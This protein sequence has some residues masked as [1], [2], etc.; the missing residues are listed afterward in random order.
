MET[1]MIQKQATTIRIKLCFDQCF[2]VDCH[3]KS[4]GLMLLWKDSSPVEIQN[5]SRRHINAVV[6]CKLDAPLWMLTGFYRHPEAAKRGEPWA[7][8]RHLSKLNSAPW[9]CLGDFNEIT[10]AF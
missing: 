9:L 8:L 7:L 10:S 6:R 3:G 2:V 1:K 5:F 4:G